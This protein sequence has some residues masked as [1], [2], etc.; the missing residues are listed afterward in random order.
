MA[1][2]PI[3]DLSMWTST[4][5]KSLQPAL[6]INTSVHYTSLMNMGNDW[7]PESQVTKNNCALLRIDRFPPPPSITS[8]NSIFSDA[9]PSPHQWEPLQSSLIDQLQPQSS[10]IKL[11]ALNLLSYCQP[12]QGKLADGKSSSDS[13]EPL[14]TMQAVL[15]S[16][17][18]R[19][20]FM[21]PPLLNRRISTI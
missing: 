4:V 5:G 14:P 19:A 11:V 21:V 8:G 13:G 2:I 3:G 16:F 10:F 9:L 6:L 1:C 12:T 7:V 15:I 17:V 18:P 20:F